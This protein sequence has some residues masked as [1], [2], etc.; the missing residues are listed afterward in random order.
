MDAADFVL[1][2]F[3]SSARTDV[4]FLVQDGADAVETVVREGVAAAQLRFHSRA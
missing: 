4:E 1:K 2:P 3:P